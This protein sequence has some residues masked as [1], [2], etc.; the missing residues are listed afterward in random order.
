[1]GR[2]FAGSGKPKNLEEL[3]VPRQ[4][5]TMSQDLGLSAKGRYDHFVHA[6]RH[7]AGELG[8]DVSNK[9]QATSWVTHRGAIG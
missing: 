1:M 5:G 4:T 2:P 6:Y 9:V 7:A 8:V 3:K